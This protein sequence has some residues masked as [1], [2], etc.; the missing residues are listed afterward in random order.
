MR[1]VWKWLMRYASE[2]D[3]LALVLEDDH[4]VFQ[5]MTWS[6]VRVPVLSVQRTSMAPKFWMEFRRLTMTFLRAMAIAPLERQTEM[7]MGSISGVR[8]TATDREKKKSL[9]PI[10]A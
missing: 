6:M 7:I 4:S 2:E 1:P 5:R 3:D 9:L 8:P 10:I